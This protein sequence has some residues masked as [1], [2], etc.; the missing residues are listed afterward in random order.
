MP[1]KKGNIFKMNGRLF[2]FREFLKHPLEIGSIIP[3]S[4]F[5]ERRIVQASAVASARVIIELGPGIGGVTRA[6]LRTMPQR[7]RLLSI[8]IN[9]NFH[10]LVSKIE[11]DR[12]IVHLGSASELREIIAQYDLDPPDA[13]ISGI[14]F[15]TMSRDTGSQIVAAVSSV[16]PPNGRFVAYQV[17]DQVA[18]LCEPFLGPWRTSI[19]LRNIPPMRIF[20]WEK[21]S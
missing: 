2:F 8:E 11:D 10:G 14:P 16:L 7:A 1:D 17:K 18:E 19:E 9:P 12:L 5:L 21:S 13:I 15:S 20:Q 6:I 3:S 4:R